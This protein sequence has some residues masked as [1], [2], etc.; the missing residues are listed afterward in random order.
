MPPLGLSNVQTLETRADLASLGKK[1]AGLLMDGGSAPAHWP[2]DDNS[3]PTLT[4]LNTKSDEY[5]DAL[6]HFRKSLKEEDAKIVCINRIQ[7]RPVWERFLSRK[8]SMASKNRGIVNQ[9]VLFFGTN[10]PTS[11][12]KSHFGFDP[13]IGRGTRLETGFAFSE[14]ASHAHQRGG[15]PKNDQRD[16]VRPLVAQFC[17]VSGAKTRVAHFYLEQTG[18]KDLTGLQGAL[19]KYFTSDC[20]PPP[21]SYSVPAWAGDLGEQRYMLLASVLTGYS[22][23]IGAK[24]EAAMQGEAMR[25][26]PVLKPSLSKG[27]EKGRL[28][29]SVRCTEAGAPVVVV[30]DAT[31]SYPLFLYTYVPRDGFTVKTPTY[32]VGEDVVVTYGS[33]TGVRARIQCMGNS[34]GRWKLEFADG[35]VVEYPIS[36]FAH[37]RQDPPPVAGNA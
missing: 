3:T 18:A 12:W 14:T 34:S 30:H 26:P 5:S 22:K 27:D 19:D 15:S 36:K 35:K 31:Q 1:F 7:N 23:D 28:Y 25:R 6:R 17:G 33:K 10:D 29:D 13:R 32:A 21:A 20:A 2:K 16:T 24:G 4:V 9:K 11:I 8:L 37:A